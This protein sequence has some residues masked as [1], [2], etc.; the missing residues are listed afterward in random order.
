MEVVTQYMNDKS[1]LEAR[2]Q[3]LEEERSSL[4]NDIA[5]LKEKLAVLELQRH[6]TSL[7]GEVE[8]LRTERAV[9]EEK[10]TT[11]SIESSSAS[12]E[13]YQV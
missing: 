9:L 6:A 4:I 1:E 11:Y 2:V 13:S 5:A 12:R 8:A 3:G 7:N 10:I